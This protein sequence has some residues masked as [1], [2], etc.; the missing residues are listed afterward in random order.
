MALGG[1]ESSSRAIIPPGVPMN[2]ESTTRNFITCGNTADVCTQTG[3]YEGHVCRMYPRW[4]HLPQICLWQTG[5]L[6]VHAEQNHPPSP[7]NVGPPFFEWRRRRTRGCTKTVSFDYEW[8]WYAS[9]IVQNVC[10]AHFRC[11]FPVFG[12]N[13]MPRIVYFR[14]H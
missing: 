12:P 7:F 3:T 14:W 6:T 5:I 11:Q 13:D 2:R 4:P 10:F 1:N 8:L 9:E